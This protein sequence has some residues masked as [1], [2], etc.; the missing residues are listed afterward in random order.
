MPIVMQHLNS[1]LRFTISG[2][3]CQ[4]ISDWEYTHDEMVF[5]EQLATGSSRHFKLYASQ[6]NN[7]SREEAEI[8]AEFLEIPGDELQEMREAEL[9]GKI[10]PR[11]FVDGRGY[12]CELRPTESQC[13]IRVSNLLTGNVLEL[14]EASAVSEDAKAIQRDLVFTI[15]GDEYRNLTLWENWVNSQAFSGR[16]AYEFGL[17]DIGTSAE[18]TDLRTDTII[19]VTNYSSW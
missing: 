3:V 18:V 8:Y 13:R 17:S 2:P 16:Y 9:E 5:R 19:N 10:K 4:R 11:Y 12:K 15:G 6:I 1:V 7:M 14:V